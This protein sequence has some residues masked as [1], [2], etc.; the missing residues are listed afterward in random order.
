MSISIILQVDALTR[1]ARVQEWATG[2]MGKENAETAGLLQGGKLK[3]R[4]LEREESSSQ[5]CYEFR[6]AKCRLLPRDKVLRV[7]DPRFDLPRGVV[8]LE[9][10]AQDAASPGD[11]EAPQPLECIDL[12][13]GMGG[14]SLGLESTGIAEVKYAVDGFKAATQTFQAAHPNAT[15]LCQDVCQFLKEASSKGYLKRHLKKEPG[16]EREAEVPKRLLIGGPPCQGFSGANKAGQGT[17]LE[18][19][20]CMA[21]F[22]EGV[23]Q[24]EPDYVIIE[25]VKGL[26]RADGVLE[27][28]ILCLISLG[29]QCQVRVLNAGSFGVAQN[30]VRTV[31]SAAAHGLPL[32]KPPRPTH[33]FHAGGYDEQRPNAPSSLAQRNK[34][35]IAGV[36]LRWQPC[37]IV[38]T[39]ALLPRES[40]R[41]VIGDLPAEEGEDMQYLGPPAS[42]YQAAMRFGSP[43][44]DCIND[45]VSSL[46]SFS[47]VT[48][49][50]IAAVPRESDPPGPGRVLVCQHPYRPPVSG[51]WRDLPDELLPDELRDPSARTNPKKFGRYGRL[52][53]DKSQ[54]STLLTQSCIRL[55]SETTGPVLH[56]DA[57]RPLTLREAARVQGIPDWVKIYWSTLAEGYKQ[58]GNGVPPPLAAALGLELKRAVCQYC[59]RAAS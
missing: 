7:L 13:C 27:S 5:T 39:C 52:M 50:R 4:M 24:L 19:N 54:F 34:C 10:D 6:P 42:A 58:C 40:V 41:S 8:L 25:N 21:L 30:R 33:I 1:L 43:D 36:P 57:D 18:K 37:V 12:F 17:K 16:K 47:N 22:L 32:P 55:N 46:S 51:D 44:S 56:P 9:D 2:P 29:F 15:V 14:L 31:I 59:E 28:I 35:A 48:V 53:W 11:N 38:P 23:V 49:A 20:V 3:V 26:L 45:H